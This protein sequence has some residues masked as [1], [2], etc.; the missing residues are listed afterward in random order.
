MPANWFIQSQ[1][2]FQIYGVS[3]FKTSESRMKKRL[4]TYVSG[5]DSSGKINYSQATSVH[6][7]AVAGLK[8]I[9]SERTSNLNSTRYAPFFKVFHNAYGFDYAG[10]HTF[11]CITKSSPI[12][13]VLIPFNITTLF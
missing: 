12:F 6:A 7:H 13:M 10:E 4:G 3:F 8:G 2:R 11:P 1:G 5:K 9:R